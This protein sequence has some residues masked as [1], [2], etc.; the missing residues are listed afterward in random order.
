MSFA[1]ECRTRFSCGSFRA[2]H[3]VELTVY[4]LSS[5]PLPLTLSRLCVLFFQEVSQLSGWVCVSSTVHVQYTLA[6]TYTSSCRSITSIALLSH[7]SSLIH[8]RW[9]ATL[10]HSQ[11]ASPQSETPLKWAVMTCSC[12]WFSLLSLI[13]LKTVVFNF[14][15]FPHVYCVFRCTVWQLSWKVRGALSIWYGLEATLNHFPPCHR[16]SAGRRYAQQAPLSE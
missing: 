10:S 7:S 12:Q 8:L 1:V 14:F 5:S 15:S 2:D 3:P 11:L 6:S 9:K 16:L 4:L 13:K